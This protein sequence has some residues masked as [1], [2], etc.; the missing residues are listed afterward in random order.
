MKTTVNQNRKTA[1]QAQSR[2]SVSFSLHRS[3]A[4]RR[5]APLSASLTV[6]AALVLPLFLFVLL[7][8][9]VPFRIMTAER[10]MPRKPSVT[11]PLPWPRCQRRRPRNTEIR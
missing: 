3:A 5:R 1:L 7:L 11:A 10:Q 8:F 4:L 9:S 2:L 6:E